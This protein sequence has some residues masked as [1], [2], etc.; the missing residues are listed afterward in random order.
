[1][2]D[3]RR[4]RN[5]KAK[6]FGALVL[7][8]VVALVDWQMVMFSWWYIVWLGFPVVG[9]GMLVAGRRRCSPFLTTFGVVLFLSGVIGGVIARYLNLNQIKANQGM[10][11]HVAAALKEHWDARGSYP[12][13][14][15]DLVPNFLVHL[16][17]PSVGVLARAPW[18][19]TS[20][21][22]ADGFVLGYQA[23][24]GVAVF[25]SKGKWSAVPVP[26]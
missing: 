18:W 4:E 3:C 1:M 21:E 17:V 13:S 2:I 14:L 20:S 25:Y 12:E 19:Y 8:P 10:G 5:M 7:T 6:L 24:D 15:A 11:E 9:V 26:W 22:Q 16:P 23:T